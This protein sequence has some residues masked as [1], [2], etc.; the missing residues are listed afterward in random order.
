M[1]I[2]DILLISIGLSMDNMA[3][4][5][6]SACA[7]TDYSFKTNLKVAVSFCLTGIICLLLGFFMGK[8][9]GL[10]SERKQNL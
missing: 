3:V 5:A 1:G 6:A 4:A 9:W 8:K 10:F 2:L 7:N